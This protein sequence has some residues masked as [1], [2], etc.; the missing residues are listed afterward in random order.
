MAFRYTFFGWLARLFGSLSCFFG[1]LAGPKGL[2]MFNL[3]YE[4]EVKRLREE[5][6]M[7]MELDNQSYAPLGPCDPG[8][9]ERLGTLGPPGASSEA[10]ARIKELLAKDSL[11]WVESCELSLLS[12]AFGDVIVLDSPGDKESL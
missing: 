6:K 10:K 5:T 4:T 11:T 3:D 12:S 2:E 1:R 7:Q 9:G 8:L